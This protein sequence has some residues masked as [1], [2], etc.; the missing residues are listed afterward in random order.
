M[1]QTEPGFAL[2]KDGGS[3]GCPEEVGSL[4]QETCGSRGGGV[5]LSLG[6]SHPPLPRAPAA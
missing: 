5:P 4:A 1:A 2:Q 6:L 3:D